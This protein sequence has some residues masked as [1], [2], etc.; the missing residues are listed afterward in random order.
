M[1]LSGF[2]MRFGGTR[3][4]R[5]TPNHPFVRGRHLVRAPSVSTTYKE[6]ENA[7]H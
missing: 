4:L 2:Q 1:K 7:S 5:I 6:I 3:T